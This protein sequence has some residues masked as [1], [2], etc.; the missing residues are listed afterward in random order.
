M[1]GATHGSHPNATREPLVV[2]WMFVPGLNLVV[3]LRQ[4]YFLRQFWAGKQGIL[5]KD[6]IAESIPLFS[7]NA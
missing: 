7:A 3:G 2:W 5:V 1:L 6:A 4:I